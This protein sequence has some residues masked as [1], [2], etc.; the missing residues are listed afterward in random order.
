MCNQSTVGWGFPGDYV[1]SCG[2]PLMR[3][4]VYKGVGF[5]RGDGRTAASRLV[6]G[7]DSVA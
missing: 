3:V 6:T 2:I 4:V 7:G 1:S 5:A